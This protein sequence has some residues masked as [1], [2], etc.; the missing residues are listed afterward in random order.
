[1]P[2]P[3]GRSWM[4]LE[5]M[6]NRVLTNLL[7][8]FPT[9]ANLL[10]TQAKRDRARTRAKEALENLSLEFKILRLTERLKDKIE[11]GGFGPLFVDTEGNDYTGQIRDTNDPPFGV[12]ATQAYHIW[13]AFKDIYTL[14]LLEQFDEEGNLI[15]G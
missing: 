10:D 5:T 15:D 7:D 4:T 14:S 3:D 9:L 11:A 6:W 1:M 2:T 8:E 12:E 13:R